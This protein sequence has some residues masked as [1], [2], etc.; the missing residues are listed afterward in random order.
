MAHSVRNLTRAKCLS[1]HLVEVEED[2]SD[3]IMI[4]RVLRV[5]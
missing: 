3:T 4:L 1:C 2:F 5:I